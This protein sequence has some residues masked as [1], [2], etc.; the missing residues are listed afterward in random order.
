MAA[1]VA[2]PP[3]PTTDPLIVATVTT[4]INYMLEIV[5]GKRAAE[6]GVEVDG[7]AFVDVN[8][9]YDMLGLRRGAVGLTPVVCGVTGRPMQITMGLVDYG[10]LDKWCRYKVAARATGTRDVY[11]QPCQGRRNG[12]GQRCGEMEKDGLL[13]H[14]ASAFLKEAFGTDRVKV[15]LCRTC[16]CIAVAPG[17]RVVSRAYCQTKDCEGGGVV[18]VEIPKPLVVFMHLL[19]LANVQMRLFV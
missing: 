11:G 9:I 18:M 13:S 7:S 19:T 8:A 17:R 1:T 3:N 12:G 15:W 6:L 16:G 10:V 4:Q 2:T 14:G 5:F